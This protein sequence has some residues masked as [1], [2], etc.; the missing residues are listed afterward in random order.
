MPV[1]CKEPFL[2]AQ[3]QPGI[4]MN[5]TRDLLIRTP[6][7]Y[8]LLNT[9]LQSPGKSQFTQYDKKTTRLLETGGELEKINHEVHRLYLLGIFIK[10]VYMVA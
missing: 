2:R 3:R 9:T 4:T 7:Q 5:R 10:L 1:I 6:S 8:L